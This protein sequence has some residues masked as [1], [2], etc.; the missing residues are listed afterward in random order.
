MLGERAVVLVL[1]HGL[2]VALIGH[3]CINLAQAQKCGFFGGASDL[4]ASERSLSSSL[5]ASLSTLALPSV[6]HN[7]RDACHPDG[8][9]PVSPTDGVMLLP[10]AHTAIHPNGGAAQ[11]C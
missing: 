7:G 2:L 5:R 1:V 10:A 11:F 9:S 3:Y 4:R 8:G 6:V